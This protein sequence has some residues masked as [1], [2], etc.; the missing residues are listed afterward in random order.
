[1]RDAVYVVFGASGD[2]EDHREWTIAAYRDE[3]MATEHAALAKA[4]DERLGDWYREDENWE[5][6]GTDGA[7]TNAYDVPHQ[8]PGS[9]VGHTE[10]SVWTVPLR[11][12]IPRVKRAKLPRATPS[13]AGTETGGGR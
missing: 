9:D 10:F 3:K 5:A 4:E 11:S 13:S 1:M 12:A 7:P 6:R 2:Y 8:Y